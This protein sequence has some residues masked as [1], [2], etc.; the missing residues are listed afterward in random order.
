MYTTP[1]PSDIR[2]GKYNS[3]ELTPPPI[4]D[5]D[6]ARPFFFILPKSTLREKP[7]ESVAAFSSSFFPVINARLAGQIKVSGRFFNLE[8]FGADE[9][10]T[11]SAKMRGVREKRVAVG[12]NVENF[13]QG[14]MTDETTFSRHFR[15]AAL[16]SFVDALRRRVGRAV[17]FYGYGFDWRPPK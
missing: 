1:P 2:K 7:F 6:I 12:R 9:S 10:E 3:Y 4:H 15:R 17:C 14:A 8:N 5:R 11:A 13:L 16:V